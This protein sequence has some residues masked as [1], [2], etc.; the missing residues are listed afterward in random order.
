[1]ERTVEIENNVEIIKELEMLTGCKLSYQALSSKDGSGVA[2]EM[3]DMSRVDNLLE[4][5][6]LFIKDEYNTADED[7]EVL[8]GWEEGEILS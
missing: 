3:L 6:G 8:N 2:V 5:L 1:M 4:R 7:D